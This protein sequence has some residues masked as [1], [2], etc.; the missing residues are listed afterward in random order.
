MKISIELEINQKVQNFVKSGLTSLYLVP[1]FEEFNEPGRGKLPK[2][3][4]HSC[5]LYCDKDSLPEA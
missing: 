2:R 4:L 3:P 5:C 1:D